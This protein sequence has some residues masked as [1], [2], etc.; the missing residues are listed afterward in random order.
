MSIPAGIAYR[1]ANFDPSATFSDAMS[2][3]ARDAASMSTIATAVPTHH[4][5]QRAW[6]IT[7]AVLGVDALLVA[8]WYADRARK[9]KAKTQASTSSSQSP[10]A[11]PLPTGL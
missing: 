9:L 7:G 2:D 8:N 1:F 6:V 5:S 11:G 3:F 4:A 10:Q